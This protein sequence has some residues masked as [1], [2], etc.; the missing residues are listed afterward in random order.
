M[1]KGDTIAADMNTK[2]NYEDK[3]T[4]MVVPGDKDDSEKLIK[5]DTDRT[6][7]TAQH[8]VK[9][10][11][12]GQKSTNVSDEKKRKINKPIVN[13]EIKQQRKSTIQ[14]LRDMI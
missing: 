12:S 3:N 2:I 1:V 7:D 13:V 10:N 5:K 11:E 8:S 6:E 14:A 4:K 9:L